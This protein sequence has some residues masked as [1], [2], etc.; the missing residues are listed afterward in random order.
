MSYGRAFAESASK[1]SH[2]YR[3]LY[4]WKSKFALAD[5]LCKNVLYN[6]SKQ[7]AYHGSIT[8]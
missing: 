2:V 8:V 4:P 3:D 6:S 5:W 7:K 1:V